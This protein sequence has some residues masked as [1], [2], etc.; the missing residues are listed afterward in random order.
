MNIESQD[1]DQGMFEKPVLI[2]EQIKTAGQL[3]EIRH[4][5]PNKLIQAMQR[6]N[7]VAYFD[8]N[9]TDDG[10]DIINEWPEPAAV[11]TLAFLEFTYNGAEIPRWLEKIEKNK[12]QP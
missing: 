12:S 11:M 4:G 6:F 5:G 3:Y 2:F 1:A 10:Q 7:D 9:T 8:P